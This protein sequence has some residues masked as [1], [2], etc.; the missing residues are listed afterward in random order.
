MASGILKQRFDEKPMPSQRR[1]EIPHSRRMEIDENVF[2]ME[3]GLLYVHSV[4][5]S[6]VAKKLTN[7]Q[8][9]IGR[10]QRKVAH[11][12]ISKHLHKTKE[13][14]VDLLSQCTGDAL[15]IRTLT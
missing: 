9:D 10:K 8:K 11:G 1:K 4:R 7:L 12:G 14:F 5:V 2:K 15:T 13:Q 3:C 6:V